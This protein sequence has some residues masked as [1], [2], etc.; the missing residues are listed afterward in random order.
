MDLDIHSRSL[1]FT[2]YTAALVVYTVLNGW[3]DTTCLSSLSTHLAPTPLFSGIL[4][5]LTPGRLMRTLRYVAKSPKTVQ[6]HL[7]IIWSLF[8]PSKFTFRSSTLAFVMVKKDQ[9]Q[10]KTDQLAPSI[11]KTL[12]IF[13]VSHWNL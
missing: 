9:R 10:K 3:A 12:T 5:T 7:R 4:M 11:L 13:T 2:A 1:V 8:R 6:L